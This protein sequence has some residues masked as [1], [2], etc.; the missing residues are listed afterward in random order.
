[1]RYNPDLV[2]L[3]ANITHQEIV[4]A[5]EKDSITEL[6]EKGMCCWCRGCKEEIEEILEDFIQSSDH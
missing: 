6:Y 1:M 4:A 2:C 3:C 5:A